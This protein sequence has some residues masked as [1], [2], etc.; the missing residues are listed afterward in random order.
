MLCC[1]QQQQLMRIKFALYFRRVFENSS[2]VSSI[3][4]HKTRTNQRPGIACMTSQGWP[5]NVFPP[6]LLTI[7]LR[8]E[9]LVSTTSYKE[10][11]LLF[12]LISTFV[13]SQIVFV[14][15][16]PKMLQDL[17]RVLCTPLILSSKLNQD[18]CC[19]LQDLETWTFSFCP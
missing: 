1:V 4:L 16:A 14:L 13:L 11:V 7:F 6:P 10:S 3:F 8:P 18:I 19:C 5:E 12:Q 15:K 9:L 2:L 17:E